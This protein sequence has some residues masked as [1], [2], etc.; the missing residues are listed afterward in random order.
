[1]QSIDHT[2]TTIIMSESCA[3]S[4]NQIP[5]KARFCKKCCDYLPIAEFPANANVCKKHDYLGTQTERWCKECKDFICLSLFRKGSV[6]FL[7]RKHMYNKSGRKAMEKQRNKPEN[8]GIISI[9]NICY[10]DNRIFKH[11]SIGLTKAEIEILTKSKSQS[12]LFHFALLPVDP[13]KIM[14]VDNVVLVSREKR[15]KMMKFF[16]SN[17]KEKYEK[18]AKKEKRRASA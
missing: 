16:K 9:R 17:N 14:S 13:T 6:D 10:I 18:I 7:C 12:E 3:D 11:S 5:E 2:C 1:V 15:D 8:V 4:N